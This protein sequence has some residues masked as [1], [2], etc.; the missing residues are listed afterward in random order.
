V[1][2]VNTPGL[3]GAELRSISAVDFLD[4]KVTRQVDYWDG[5]RNPVIIGRPA[6]DQYPYDL[7]LETVGEQA[8]PEISKVAGQ[9]NTALSAGDA[10]TATALFSYDAIFED[11]TLR[12]RE[13]GQLAIGRYLQRALPNLPYGP[14][15]TLRHV[16][17]SVQGGG[18]EWQ[19]DGQ[20]T[21]NGI[22]ALELDNNGFITQLSAVWDGSRI[23][24]SAVQALAMLSIET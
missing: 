7:G 2:Y 5:R 8:A 10:K 11:F 9:L 17:G 18:Y 6:A 19:A 1:Y 16:L 15:T 4:G 23:N 20:P 22:T 24:D 21:I 14:G 12:T 13:E 3:F